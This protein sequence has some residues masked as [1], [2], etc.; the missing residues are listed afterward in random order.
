MP[1]IQLPHRAE[2]KADDE[3]CQKKLPFDLWTLMKADGSAQSAAAQDVLENCI[4]TTDVGLVELITPEV[5]LIPNSTGMETFRM[6]FVPVWRGLC[7]P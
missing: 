4:E 1:K 2:W 5:R 3:P 7:P 6:V